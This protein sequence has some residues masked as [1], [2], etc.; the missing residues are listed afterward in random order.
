M[1]RQLSNARHMPLRECTLEL[2]RVRHFCDDNTM[3]MMVMMLMM[4]MM[5]MMVMMMMLMA[6]IYCM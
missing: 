3:M 1:R 5:V 4:M 2:G 6:M